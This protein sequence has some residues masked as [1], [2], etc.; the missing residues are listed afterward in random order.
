MKRDID[1]WLQ[2]DE[3]AAED[4]GHWCTACNLP[5]VIRWPVTGI[6][7]LGVTPGMLTLSLCVECREYLSPTGERKTLG[8]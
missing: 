5:S 3:P 7:E 6:S 4:V 1:V 8:K 2:L